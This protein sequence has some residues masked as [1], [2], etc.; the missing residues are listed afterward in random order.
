M[1]KIH[2]NSIKDIVMVTSSNVS[3]NDGTIRIL[4]HYFFAKTNRV[5]EDS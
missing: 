2:D 5:K 1:K 4:T 3:S